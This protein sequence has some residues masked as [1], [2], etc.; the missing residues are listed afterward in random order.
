MIDVLIERKIISSDKLFLRLINNK[1]PRLKKYFIQNLKQHSLSKNVIENSLI[2]FHDNNIVDFTNDEYNCIFENLAN[3]ELFVKLLNQ[4]FINS[5]INSDS[6]DH[7]IYWVQTQNSPISELY[8]NQNSEV[9]LK[10]TLE[11][12]QLLKNLRR[13]GIVSKFN[14]VEG[15]YFSVYN[16]RKYPPKKNIST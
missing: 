15:D 12:E 2:S 6:I 3:N 5:K 10:K 4:A 8:I 9:K 11:N 7:V 14:E 13:I 1:N 16:K